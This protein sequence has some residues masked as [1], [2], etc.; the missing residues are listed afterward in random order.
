ML[1]HQGI[2]IVYRKIEGEN[3]P[4]I[5]LHGLT[6]S[7]RAWDKILPYLLR[8]SRTIIMPDMR[9]CG[10]SGRPENTDDY[11]LERHAQD[12]FVLMEKEGIGKAVIV[13]HC[14]GSM[15]AATFGSLYPQKTERLILI[16]TGFNLPWFISSAFFYYPWKILSIMIVFFLKASY[17]GGRVDYS[18]FSFL[19]DIELRRMFIDIKATGIGSLFRQFIALSKWQGR[20]FFRNIRIPVLVLAGKHDSIYPSEVFNQVMNILNHAK[21]EYIGGNHILIINNSR[22]VYNIIA[23]FIKKE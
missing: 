14:F 15:V 5:L 8:L 23:D 2:R 18:Q 21:G 6:S 7:Y 4:L 22:E 17:Q 11:E 1:D 9:G 13:G 3:P 12:I 16:N 10:L 20:K 19:P